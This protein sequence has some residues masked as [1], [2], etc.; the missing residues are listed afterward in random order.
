M[1]VDANP[2]ALVDALGLRSMKFPGCTLP[3]AM[4]LEREFRKYCSKM[5]REF[6]HFQK[7]LQPKCENA[8]LPWQLKDLCQKKNRTIRCRTERDLYCANSCAYTELGNKDA[9]ISICPAALEKEPECY[10]WGCTLMHELAHQA[11]VK[12]ERTA[13][14]VPSCLGC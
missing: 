13:R 8:D 3:Q 10:R 6:E 2:L 1:Y 7:C 12:S 11:G 4:E 5:E 14:G 9:P